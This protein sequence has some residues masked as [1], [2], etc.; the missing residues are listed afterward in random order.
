MVH[1][2]G[3]PKVDERGATLSDQLDPLCELLTAGCGGKGRSSKGDSGGVGG[4]DGALTSGTGSTGSHS[5]LEGVGERTRELL[6]TLMT[7]RRA[8]SLVMSVSGGEEM[9][10]QELFQYIIL[11][12]FYN[13]TSSLLTRC[14]R[15]VIYRVRRI[16]GSGSMRSAAKELTWA[17]ET[18]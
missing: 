3:F 8:R 14:S 13:S 5:G 12:Q 9:R 1:V 11:F 6:L 7:L 15:G 2:L 10:I 18:G 17:T 16:N 4:T